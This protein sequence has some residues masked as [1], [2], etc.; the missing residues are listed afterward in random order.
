METVTVSK[1]FF[2]KILTDVEVL[3][4]DVELALDENVKKR[5]LDMKTGKVQGKTEKE[6]DSYLKKRGVHLE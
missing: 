6:L 2:T 4:S 3:I 1:E 5:L